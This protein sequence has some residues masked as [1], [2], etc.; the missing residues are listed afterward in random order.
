LNGE[1]I[2]ESQ[3]GTGLKAIGKVP[4]YGVVGQPISLDGSDSKGASRYRWTF[5]NGEGWKAPKKDA[6]A[7]ITYTKAGRYQVILQ[8]FDEQGNNDL[9]SFSLAIVH[10]KTFV[11]RESSTIIRLEGGTSERIAVVSPDSNEVTLLERVKDT[12][13]V[14]RRLKTLK[15]PRTL[16]QK[17]DWLLVTCQDEDAL[18]AF[19]LSGDK[20]FTFKFD[21]GARPYGA[22]VHK[23]NIFVTLQAKGQVAELTFTGT[24]EPALKKTHVVVK[25][26]RGIAVLPDGR[27]L[28]TRWRSPSDKAWLVT[29]EPATG[30]IEPWSL[31]FDPQAPSDTEIGG[32]PS[33]LNQALVSPTG[34]EIAIPSL[35]ANI[36]DGTARSGTPLRDDTSL[37][38]IV[39]TISLPSGKE[40]FQRRL[41]FDSRGFLSSGVFSS[42]GD[43]LF[44]AARGAQMVERIDMLRGVA[45]GSIFKVGHS[46]EGLVL[47]KDDRYLYVNAYLS[48]QVLVFEVSSFDTIP[49]P[50]ARLT[51]PTKEPLSPEIL[52]GKQLFNDSSD[53]RIAKENYIACAHCHLE[54]D[55]DHLVWDFTQRGE[56]LRN[57]ISLLGRKG[58]GDG[59]IHW[60]GNF[61]EIH[62]FEHDIRGAF[63]GKGLMTDEQF[64]KGTRNQTLGDKKKGISKDLD[65]LAAYVT[66]LAAHRRSPFRAKD[67]SLTEAAKRGKV[68][69]DSKELD[70]NRCHKGP[71]LT[72][73]AFPQP[74]KPLLHDVGT[75]KKTSGKRLNQTLSGID[76]PTLH[77]LW[78]SAPYL[79][80]GSAKT[81]KD[82]LVTQN[83]QDKHGKTSHLSKTQI[84]DL[85]A[86]L[87]SL[88][89]KTD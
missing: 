19:S 63:G 52:R 71:R 77:G 20:R 68:L 55:S 86:Y 8:V 15:N 26:A 88:D 13:S 1:T 79:H 87:N 36:R 21:Y 39:S 66:S 24:K 48:R 40:L 41:Q 78:D 37:R 76:T 46:P 34:R 73:S 56:G 70:C 51:I 35:Q 89:G 30:K 59:P 31:Q 32:I 2:P 53:L 18:Q 5:G 58:A 27:L 14:K 29:L 72:D 84:T 50:I 6:K 85:I 25:D 12:F 54:G 16:T 62:D 9:T 45:S 57:S 82:V 33:Y 10:P 74:G 17:D 81:L 22:V 75:L 11:P 23:G 60:S 28:I 3:P 65:A 64:N 43:Y 69:F 44:V 49:K 80:D 7:Q 67:G 47:S 38:G 83:K 42:R 4:L 61:D